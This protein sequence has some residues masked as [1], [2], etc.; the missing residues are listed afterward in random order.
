[1]QLKTG[2]KG[3]YWIFAIQSQNKPVICQEPM[4]HM[5]KYPEPQQK[6]AVVAVASISGREK[7]WS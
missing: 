2:F 3:S 4:E 5:G 6:Y 7:R 1:M